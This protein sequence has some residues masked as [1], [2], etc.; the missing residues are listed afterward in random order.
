[1]EYMVT[2][3]ISSNGED[4]GSTNYSNGDYEIYHSYPNGTSYVAASIGGQ[5]EVAFEDSTIQSYSLF[6]E[7]YGYFETM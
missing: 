4:Y 6:N 7:T 1:M 5:S 3:S 2:Y